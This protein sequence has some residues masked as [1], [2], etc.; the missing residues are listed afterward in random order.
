MEKMILYITISNNPFCEVSLIVFTEESVAK[1]QFLLVL[2]NKKENFQTGE[3]TEENNQ[4][5]GHSCS[6]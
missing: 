5:P 1:L 3:N 4:L 2:A 6:N